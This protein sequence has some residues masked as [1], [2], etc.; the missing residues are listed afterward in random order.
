MKKNAD[1]TMTLTAKE[2][3]VLELIVGEWEEEAEATLKG[4]GES[5]TLQDA[6]IVDFN[7][8]LM[9]GDGFTE[10][11]LAKS[12]PIKAPFATGGVYR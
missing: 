10:T 2:V 7:I 11:T 3:E 8:Q 6:F 5:V 9:A 1:G 12:S 4:N